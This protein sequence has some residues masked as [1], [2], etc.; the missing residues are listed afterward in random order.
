MPY[1]YVRI[2]GNRRQVGL[3][4]GKLARPLMSV[5]L[6]QSSTWEALRRWRDHPYVD[7]LAQHAQASLPAIWEE[8]EGMAEGLRMPV[9][10]VLLWNCR[11]DLL[12]STADG[13][14]TVALKSADGARWIGHNEDGDPYLYGRCHLVDVALDD[15]PGYVS[16]Y[17]PGSLPGHT[18][19][20]NRAGLVQT[21]NNLRT[22]QRHPG[23]PR[24]FLARAV[25]DCTTLDEAIALLRD[26]PHSGGFHHT[27]GSAS[28][29]RLISAEV[30]PGAVSLLDIGT[31]YGHANH[32]IHAK[33]RAQAQI[34]TESSRDRQN[35]IEGIVDGWSPATGSADL[36]A[37]L[38]DT[39]GALPILRTDAADPDG[40]NTLA[41][42]VFEIR[43][44][45]VSLRV[46]DRRTM[47]DIALDVMSE[48]E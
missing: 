11:G 42:A 1:K 31:R 37:A 28:D 16:F 17:Y 35:R 32:M 9:K 25:L 14:T 33:T 45:D 7:E 41:T 39:L 46:Y 24:M 40:E 43:D 47:A 12:H 22:R 21:I 19:G 36:L 29:P 13:C 3:A 8:L 2:A 34:V 5:Y 10:D 15:A 6:A 23:V 48:P 38:H 30:T 27:L 44:D 20:A 4:L 18:F 26:L